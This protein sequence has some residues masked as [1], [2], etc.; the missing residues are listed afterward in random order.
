MER[1]IQYHSLTKLR[2]LYS[3]ILAK[4]RIQK[5]RTIIKPLDSGFHR[6][7]DFEFVHDTYLVIPAVTPL[8][9][10][11]VSRFLYPVIPAVTLENRNPEIFYA[12]IPSKDGIQEN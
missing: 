12:V 9:N 6:S 2:F 1:F 11:V 3:V 8:K 7:D 10:G 5:Y 4:A